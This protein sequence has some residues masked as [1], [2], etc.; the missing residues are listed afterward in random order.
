MHI[1]LGAGPQNGPQL[2]AKQRQI[3]QREPDAAQTQERISSLRRLREGMNL[4]A[5]MSNVRITT[6]RSP[7]ALHDVAI[8]LKMFFFGRLAIG[9]EVEELGAIQADAVAAALDAMLD[10]VRKFDV[11][12]QFDAHA[13]GRFGR[14][15]RSVAELQ[16]RPSAA[17]SACWRYWATV[18]ASGCRMI[19]ALDRR[20]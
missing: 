13:V 4:S 17:A 20:R 3:A 9:G 1:A 11:A 2:R 18:S 7:I 14:Q 15:S 10:L 16:P 12:H 8:G 5:P 6:G 19:D